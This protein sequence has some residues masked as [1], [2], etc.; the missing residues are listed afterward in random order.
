MFDFRDET[1]SGDRFHSRS[2]A[3]KDEGFVIEHRGWWLV[4]NLVAHPL[5]GILPVRWAFQFHDWTSRQMA[6]ETQ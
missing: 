4:H 1:G 6:G 5:I 2:A 3:A